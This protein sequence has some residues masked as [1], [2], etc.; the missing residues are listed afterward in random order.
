M[1]VPNA[2]WSS[3][4]YSWNL[5]GLLKYP[6][7]ASFLTTS[8]R[9]YLIQLLKQDSNNQATHY[10]KKFLWQAITDYKTYLQMTVY[11][12]C[13]FIC[14]RQLLFVR[15]WLVPYRIV[16]PVY[17]VSLFTPSIIADLGFTAARAQLLSIPPFVCGCALTIVVGIYSDRMNIRGPFI[18]GGSFISLIGYIVL[19]TQSAPG[20]GYAGAIIACMGVYPT[21]AVNLAWAG[22]NAGGDAKRGIVLAMVI[23]FGNLGGWVLICIRCK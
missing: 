16:I 23:G 8:E 7:T 15:C 5:N 14:N 18:A 19:Y 21:I 4:V 6:E 10:N 11:I 22:G 1:W 20:V 9:E 17:A 3:V 12:S 13:V 2:C